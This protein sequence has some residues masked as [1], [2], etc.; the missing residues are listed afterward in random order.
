MAGAKI[1]SGIKRDHGMIKM[2]WRMRLAKAKPK[3]K[4]RDVSQLK[5]DEQSTPPTR[6][7]SPLNVEPSFPA[8]A[9]QGEA[10]AAFVKTMAEYQTEEAE[11]TAEAGAEP[12][13]NEREEAAEET[14]DEC[15]GWDAIESAWKDATR[16]DSAADAAEAEADFELERFWFEI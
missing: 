6:T 13:M 14:A 9:I 12:E 10:T 8:N 5:T 2:L 3:P 1:L 7:P 4:R 11:A 15:D 16:A